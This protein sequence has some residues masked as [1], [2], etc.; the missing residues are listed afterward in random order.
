MEFQEL[1]QMI[2]E[3]N[4]LTKSALECAAFLLNRARE[5]PPDQ[6]KHMLKFVSNLISAEAD[7]VDLTTEQW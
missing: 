2:R 5:L 4:E 1:Q 6:R 7:K 3:K